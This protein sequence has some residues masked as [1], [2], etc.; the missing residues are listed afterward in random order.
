MSSLKKQ[1]DS[2]LESYKFKGEVEELFIRYKKRRRIKAF[3][4]SFS[5]VFAAAVLLLGIGT[6]FFGFYSKNEFDLKVS[7]IT[8]GDS[9]T[10]ITGEKSLV[11]ASAGIVKQY[12]KVAYDKNGVE[13]IDNKKPS[14]YFKKTV[15]VPSYINLK[16]SDEHIKKIKAE[17][18]E[19]GSLYTESYDDINGKNLSFKSGDYISWIPN[20]EKLT[21]TLKADIVKVPSTIKNDKFV[22]D[23][24]NS[25]L[26]TEDDY[27]AYFGDIITLTAEKD[28][29][30]VETVNIA[31]T[32]DKDGRYYTSIY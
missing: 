27:N 18:L 32:L 9:E 3:L 11:K 15:I 30:S 8:V 2:S 16:I 20:C 4:S 26:K 6:D 10:S 1:I 5:A 14:Q 25:M 23:E 31:V 7:A 12:Q 22:T 19:N 29:N 28:D 21:K 17:C 24:I 13:I